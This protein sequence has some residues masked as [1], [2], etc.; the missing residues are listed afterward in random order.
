MSY[1]FI[2]GNTSKQTQTWTVE[3]E[4]EEEVLAPGHGVEYADADDDKIGVNVTNPSGDHVA[5]QLRRS[6]GKFSLYPAGAPFSLHV[7][8]SNVSIHC[9]DFGST[10]T[11]VVKRLQRS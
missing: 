1:N 7:N 2:I 10:G 3:N 11:E 4:P 6:G 8:G 5:T 9:S